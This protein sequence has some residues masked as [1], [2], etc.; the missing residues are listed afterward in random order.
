LSYIALK[1]IHL[2]TVAVSFALFL[3]RGVWMV[4]DS[5]RLNR[6]WVR[7]LP[8]VNDTVLLA[9]GVWLAFMLRETP[10]AS[11][12]LTAK[13]LALPVYIGLGVLALRP[14]RTKRVRIAAWLAALAVFAYIIAVALTR[15]PSL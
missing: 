9:A 4:L 5:E 10:G 1:H 7:V 2:A 6:R 12:W 15:S 11:P 14:G 3:L 13:L 8:H